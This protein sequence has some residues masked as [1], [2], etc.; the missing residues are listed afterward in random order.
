MQNGGSVGLGVGVGTPLHGS[1][2]AKHRPVDGSSC[3][4]GHHDNPIGLA[5][6]C[7]SVQHWLCEVVKNAPAASHIWPRKHAPS[8]S[9]GVGVGDGVE[10]AH[11]LKITRQTP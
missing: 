5:I 8:C 9:A 7:E 3:P 6:N 4:G 11:C 2:H 10:E 1:L